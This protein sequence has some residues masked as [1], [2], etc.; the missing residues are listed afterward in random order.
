MRSCASLYSYLL[1]WLILVAVLLDWWNS[2]VAAGGALLT[3]HEIRTLFSE[4][5]HLIQREDTLLRAE[6]VALNE[7]TK[8]SRD[9]LKQELAEARRDMLAVLLNEG[10]LGGGG[11]G[12]QLNRLLSS[13]GSRGSGN[14]DTDGGWLSSLAEKS[15]LRSGGGGGGGRGWDRGDRSG[16]GDLGAWDA[17]FMSG[18]RAQLAN[19]AGGD[20]GE[21]AAGQPQPVVM[22]EAPAEDDRY[23][24]A[25]APQWSE[26]R[27]DNKRDG[28]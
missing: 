21:K 6:V 4:L 1:S 8:R 25:M 10:R 27:R 5:I 11:V 23:K 22:G 2:S 17:G 28:K 13:G 14:D 12:K 20:S 15:G 26:G 19:L 3:A 18:L 24:Q 7:N 16:E 9:E